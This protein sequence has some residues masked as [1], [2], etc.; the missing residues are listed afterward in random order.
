MYWQVGILPGDCDLQ[1]REAMG[2]TG[3][4]WALGDEGSA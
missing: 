1:S 2:S 3:E 4:C